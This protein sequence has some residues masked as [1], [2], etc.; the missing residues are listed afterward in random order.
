MVV[1][2]AWLL[3]LVLVPSVAAQALLVGLV[4]DVPGTGPGHDAVAIGARNDTHLAGLR[5]SDGEDSWPLPD[6]LLPAGATLWIVGNASAWQAHGGAEPFVV[7]Q[8]PLR[9][10][11]DGD[12]VALLDAG[13]AVVDFVAYGDKD[14]SGTLPAA[15]PGLVLQ[16][17]GAWT[18]TDAAQD[19][20]TPRRHRLGES[21]LD[22]PVFQ[23]DAVTL[24][25]S[26][27]ASFAVLTDLIGQA[28]ERLHLHVYELRSAALADALVLAKQQHPRLD[29]QVLVDANPVGASERDRHA[30][31]DAL[32]RIQA[33]GGHA[34][35][36][37]NGRYDDHHLKVLVADDAVA[38]QSENWV[39][40]GVPADPSWGNRGWGAIVEG[41]DLADWFA[42]WMASDR[43]A[44]DVTPFDL[45]SFAPHF[46]PPPRRAARTGDYAPA[47]APLRLAGP[48][49]ITP[50]VS[51]DHTQDPRDDP[52]A[53]WMAA[54]TV[55]IDAQQLDVTLTASNG[56]GWQG[57]DPWTAA[58][59]AAAHRGVPVRVQA[60][61]PFSSTDDGN[62]LALTWLAEQ[63]VATQ[64]LDRPGLATL[65]N[66][67]FVIDDRIV[68]GST[69]GNH[70]S[71]SA[72]REVSL[73]IAS[74]AA[75]QWGRSLMATDWDPPTPDRD[76]SVPG[77]DLH[78]LPAA[79]W[80]TLLALAGVVHALRGRR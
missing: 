32:R 10:A 66:K 76:W 33:A 73:A 47:V 58:Y 19:W 38:V 46:E 55:R 41:D 30:T 45:A 78:A 54:A 17:D 27:D 62:T 1:R 67:A 12:D 18:D 2:L 74:P 40:S 35:L 64:I 65:H 25:A 4:P 23:A 48:V 50:L 53:A 57:E 60:A 79:P 61:A 51:P 69:N 44:W 36:A 71:R 72:N 8:P 80:P 3:V 22:Q 59:S 21:Q 29:L 5:L 37:G 70:H 31:A 24:Y 56:L 20:V 11:D 68:L 26:P 34:V 9:L 13:G 42:A 52:V 75:A 6:V 28:R 14:A 49:A 39:E 77:Q 43:S 16:R 15:S 7:M 63:G